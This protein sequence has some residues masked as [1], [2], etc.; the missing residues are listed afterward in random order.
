M[1]KFLIILGC[2]LITSNWFSQNDKPVFSIS[3]SW[4]HRHYENNHEFYD[5]YRFLNYDIV[6]IP[7]TNRD[8]AGSYFQNEDVEASFSKNRD[9]IESEDPKNWSAFKFSHKS[10]DF[11]MIYKPIG[12]DYPSLSE[13]SYDDL[14]SWA[15]L[16][17]LSHCIEWVNDERIKLALVKNERSFLVSKGRLLEQSIEENQLRKFFYRHVSEAFADL[18][19]AQ[20]IYE[21]TKSQK[22]IT[23]MIYVRDER[24]CKLSESTHWTSNY[25]KKLNKDLSTS[26]RNK[27]EYVRISIDIISNNLEQTLDSINFQKNHLSNRMYCN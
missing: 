26:H 21:K 24:F 5:Y 15:I 13:L 8:K 18:M 6:P 7:E 1:K 17:E 22:L 11:C 2:I 27:Q 10:H 25:L 23:E 12:H 9:M 3:N 19:T 20:V 16:H 14:K 4:V